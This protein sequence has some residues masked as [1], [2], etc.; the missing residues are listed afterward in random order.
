MIARGLNT[1]KIVGNGPGREPA[2]S[3]DESTETRDGL[4]KD[5]EVS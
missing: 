1:S 5:D 4:T 3:I 2:E